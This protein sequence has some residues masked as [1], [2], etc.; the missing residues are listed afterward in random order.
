MLMWGCKSL[1]FDHNS[2]IYGQNPGRGVAVGGVAELL[3]FFG[4]SEA[5]TVGNG[6][7]PPLRGWSLINEFSRKPVA[8][9][10][11]FFRPKVRLVSL[12]QESSIVVCFNFPPSLRY[13][14]ATEKNPRGPGNF[15]CNFW[16]KI[17]KEK[18]A[19]VFTTFFALNSAQ[20]RL[21][22]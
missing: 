3:P 14:L 1:N 7:S 8:P 18:K 20:R 16:A 6:G 10:P 19:G 2:C 13:S 11:E 22:A 4:K 5:Y 15:L 9:I 12:L 17:E 21:S